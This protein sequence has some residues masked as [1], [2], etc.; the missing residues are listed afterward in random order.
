MSLCVSSSTGVSVRHVPY[1]HWTGR[2]GARSATRG[3]HGDSDGGSTSGSADCDA[4]AERILQLPAWADGRLTRVSVIMA[5]LRDR[6]GDRGAKRVVNF[7]PWH[8]L[9]DPAVGEHPEIPVGVG[10]GRDEPEV[11]RLRFDQ[12]VELDQD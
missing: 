1:G 7:L 8:D 10:R 4:I 3:S 2:S 5:L 12:R 11:E 9:L 6:S